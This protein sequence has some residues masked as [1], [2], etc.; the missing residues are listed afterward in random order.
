MRQ[1]A[2]Q[3][4]NW[5]APIAIFLIVYSQYLIFMVVPN[6]VVMGPVQR[7]FYFH[8]GSAIACYVAILV[9]VSASL[10][11]LAT[12]YNR[13]DGLAEAAGEVSLLLSSIVLA[14]G[15]IWGHRAWNTWFSWEPRLVSFLLLWL[16][17][18]AYFTLRRF[19]EPSR[20]GSHSAV[21]AI[22]GAINVPIVVYSIKLLPNIAQLH[23]QVVENRGLKDPSFQSTMFI[24]M[25]AFSVL[26]IWMIA[27]RARSVWLEQIINKR[28]QMRGNDGTGA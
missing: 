11:Y 17:L 26:T 4:T 1:I 8:V 7:I 20:V 16:V 22:I 25:L 14:T 21:L 3:I 19:D 9:L 13:Y 24:S 6:E 5:L 23:P 27:L 28:L 12:R 18:L 2:R 10:A 15:M